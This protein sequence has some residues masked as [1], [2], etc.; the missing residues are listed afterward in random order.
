MIPFGAVVAHLAWLIVSLV[1]GGLI[2]RLTLDQL[3]AA[4]GTV[5]PGAKDA[6]RYIGYAERA[7]IHLA[8]L[9]DLPWI[10]PVVVG[11]KTLVRFPEIQSESQRAEEDT[12]ETPRPGSFVEYYLVG[13]L[14]SVAWAVAVG[15]LARALIPLGSCGW[16]LL[17]LLGAGLALAAQQSTQRA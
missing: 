12:E 16:V 3:G 7:L 4:P 9:G 1:A 6:G 8:I 11:L 15:L 10:V 5:R 2:T 17:P 13:T 14:V